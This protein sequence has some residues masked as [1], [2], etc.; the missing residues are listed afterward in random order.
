M[1]SVAPLEPDHRQ[2]GHLAAAVPRVVALTGGIGSG[3]SAVRKMFETLGVP[4]IDADQ[5]ARAIHQDPL[6]PANKEIARAFPDAVTPAGTLHRGS[7]RA[8]FA[9]DAAANAQL[10]QILKPYVMS[11]IGQWTR[12][13]SAPYVIWESALILDENIPADRVL[14]VDARDDTRIAR[15]QA[16]NPDW[17][18]EQIRSIL[19][20]QLP[21][22]AYVSAAHDVID[23]DGSL[24]ELQQ[25]VKGLDRQYKKLWER[26]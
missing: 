7:L 20:I 1:T 14:V 24:Q 6:H 15:I 3:K 16:R 8:R 18:I 22:A 4:G 2:S 9:I 13:Q 11:A 12:A 5:V 25:H 19:A 26:A 10:K 21:R 23:N 17:P